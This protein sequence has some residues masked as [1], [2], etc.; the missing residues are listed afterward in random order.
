MSNG[1]KAA[2]ITG[3]V[4]VLVG[5][6][7]FCCAMT[8]N[9]W[10]FKRM[11]TMKYETNTYD[12][13][14]DF[15]NIAINTDTDDIIFALSKDGTCKVV[16]VEREKVR[17]TVKVQEDTLSITVTDSR[18]WMDN[19]FSFSAEVPKIT[20]FLPESRYGALQVRESTGDIDLPEDFS[21]ESID[22]KAS[23]GDVNCGASAAG[24]LQI[25]L[26]TGDIRMNQ[27]SAEDLTL[28]VTTGHVDVTSA[29]CRGHFDLTVST[30]KSELTDIRCRSFSTKGDTG[31]I[32]MDS[33]IA[34]ESISVERTT[35]K[36]KF[37][38][39]DAAEIFIETDTGD[40]A[41][42][43]L[44]DKVFI[45]ESDTG[46][47]DVPKTITGGRCEI[48]TDTGDIKVSVKK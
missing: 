39:C 19:L 23:T 26:S 21:F 25:R 12:V 6:I 16:C 27:V 11:N 47:I 1:T 28:S 2:L 37:E 36:V 46:R 10:D 43:L 34:E 18:N 7:G 44:S 40:V 20:V 32:K 15:Q 14:E 9:R 5:L 8:I 31:N 38:K 33:L 45:T 29:V 42:T 4:L 41:G 17:H 13:N 3:T 48:T 35:G 30:G 24:L 22:I